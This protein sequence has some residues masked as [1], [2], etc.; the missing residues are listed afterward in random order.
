[1]LPKNEINNSQRSPHTDPEESKDHRDSQCNNLPQSLIATGITTTLIH[2]F[3][4]IFIFSFLLFPIIITLDKRHLLQRYLLG[5]Q[6]RII[7][8]S[9]NSKRGKSLLNL[10][11]YQSKVLFYF[12]IS[13]HF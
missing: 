8:R 6:I 1:M 7:L 4:E 5:P 13:I 3:Y 9:L 11:D 2:L 12:S 10:M